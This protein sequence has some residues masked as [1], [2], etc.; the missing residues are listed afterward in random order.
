MLKHML[1][2]GGGPQAAAAATA[3]VNGG[4]AGTRMPATASIVGITRITD[5]SVSW[6]DTEI[7]LSTLVG[8]TPSCNTRQIAHLVGDQLL[9][10]GRKDGIPFGHAERKS[11]FM[12]QL[13]PGATRIAQP[14]KLLC[15]AH[16]EGE[17]ATELMFFLRTR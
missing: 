15:S 17:R 11:L 4:G 3:T 5:H 6:L 10:D 14:S 8:I 12:V 1:T 7:R 16:K 13:L 9:S 2:H